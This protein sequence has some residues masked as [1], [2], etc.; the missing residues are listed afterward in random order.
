[1]KKL[2][3]IGLVLVLSLTGRVLASD[4]ELFKVDDQKINNEF[5]DLNKLENFVNANEGV[6]LEE[7]QAKNLNVLDG[8]NENPESFQGMGSTLRG[9]GDS[10]LGIPPFIWG[11]VLSWVGVL[12][13][14]LIAEDR[15]MTKMALYGCLAGAV[16]WL[17]FSI[18]YSVIWGASILFFL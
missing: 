16:G 15:E 9:G 3:S 18:L 1:M 14:Y 17:V 4:A 13:V 8:L 11:C 2:L 12:I 5:S 6:T 7:V 10:P